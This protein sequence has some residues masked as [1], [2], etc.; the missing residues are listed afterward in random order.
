MS[1]ERDLHMLDD[2][3]QHVHSRRAP[4]R[5][6]RRPHA[7]GATGALMFFA[8]NLLTKP[9]KPVCRVPGPLILIVALLAGQ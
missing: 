6:E 5:G 9:S 4:T 2:S 8:S 7:I 1:T 3:I